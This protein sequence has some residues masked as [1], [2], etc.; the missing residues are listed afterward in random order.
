MRKTILFPSKKEM[1]LGRWSFTPN[2]D[3]RLS[4]RQVKNGPFRESLTLQGK[5]ISVTANALV[6][7]AYGTK[8]NGRIQ[9]RLI[10]LEGIW[11][12]DE[13][14]RIIFQ[15]KKG[16]PEK[17]LTFQGVWE[18]G[19]H[20][21]ILYHYQKKDPD[22]G[23]ELEE[24]LSF[25]GVW[26]IR[27]KDHLTYTLGLSG[28]SQFDFRATLQSSSLI[29]KKGEIRYQIGIHLSGRKEP[30]IREVVLFGKWKL[31]K[32][33]ALS[34][35]VEYEERRRHAISFKSSFRI[36]ENDEVVFALLDTKGRRL[37]LEVAFERSF[38]EEQGKAFLRFY[39]DAVESRVEGGV[40]VPF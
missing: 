14:N 2:H 28:K 12:A 16:D 19:E 35:Q 32:A 8:E 38:F 30:V 9:T 13:R 26:E 5:I 1:R 25:Q 4:L 36:N 39:R 17:P 10:R 33:L 7:A 27:Q 6:F 18:I 40:R 23:K 15:V 24:T 22:T 21:E 29:A 20:H 3:L 34:F 11:Q 31:S 37:G